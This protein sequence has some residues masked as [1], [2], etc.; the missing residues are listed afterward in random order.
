MLEEE[1]QHLSRGVRALRIGV[2][3]SGAASR[4]SIVV[5]PRAP[6]GLLPFCYPIRRHAIERAARRPELVERPIIYGICHLR[7]REGAGGMSRPVALPRPAGRALTRSAPC[8]I[9]ALG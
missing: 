9:C 8:L 7:R 4:P 2:G 1:A 5:P 3:A 6:N